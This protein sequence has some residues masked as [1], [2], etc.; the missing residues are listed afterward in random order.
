QHYLMRHNVQ[1]VV[2]GDGE[3]EQDDGENVHSDGSGE[4]DEVVFHARHRGERSWFT[5]ILSAPRA[6]GRGAE[7][8]QNVSTR[9][10]PPISALR[11]RSLRQQTI[12]KN[13]GR[14]SP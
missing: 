13:R 14:R 2:R 1:R 7:P 3:T 5:K 9:S 6:A 12:N 10:W 8:C 4:R 11:P